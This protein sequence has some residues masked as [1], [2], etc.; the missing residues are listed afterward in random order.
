[1][2]I[3]LVVHG[4]TD[5]VTPYFAS[6]LLLRQLPPGLGER[7]KL[8]VY[9]GGHMFYTRDASRAAFRADAER[10]FGAALEAR[11]QGEKAP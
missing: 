3:A 5:L 7:A 4:F 2:T 1:M 11:R 9:P 6:E 10:L 8:A